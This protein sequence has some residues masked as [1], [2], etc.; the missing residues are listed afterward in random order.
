MTLSRKHVGVLINIIGSVCINLG[1]NL[2]SSGHR[3]RRRHD[4]MEDIDDEDTEMRP[5]TLPFE[6]DSDDANGVELRRARFHPSLDN[7]SSSVSLLDC[8]GGSVDTLDEQESEDV[9]RNTTQPVLRRDHSIKEAAEAVASSAA[10]AATG[11]MDKAHWWFLSLLRLFNVWVVGSC[12][13]GLGTVAVFVSYSFAPQSLLAPLGSAQFVSNVVF[14]RIIHRA[15]VT[16]RM[17]VSTSV[18]LVGI[19]LVVHFSPGPNPDYKELDAKK[20]REL[21][22]FISYQVNKIRAQI[23]LFLNISLFRISPLPPNRSTCRS[24]TALRWRSSRSACTSSTGCIGERS[25]VTD[26]WRWTPW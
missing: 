7:D 13:F 6:E 23:V 19:T 24:C 1:N 12:I 22:S 9:F 15:T 26:P 25:G 8:S 21:Y 14:A 2:Q 5:E 18:I 3:G 16:R 11:A 4:S 10:V 17:V 20:I